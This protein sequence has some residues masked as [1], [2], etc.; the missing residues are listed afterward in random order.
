MEKVTGVIKS[1]DA[2]L[3]YYTVNLTT[4]QR[5]KFKSVTVFQIGDVVSGELTT[6]E[7]TGI[8]FLQSV[9]KL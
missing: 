9:H 3:G 5:A 8:H 1:Y 6:T 7:K 4:G 2:V